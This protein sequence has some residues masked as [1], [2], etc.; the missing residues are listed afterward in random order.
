MAKVAHVRESQ[1]GAMA[2]QMLNMEEVR[3]AAQ[4]GV[5]ALQYLLEGCSF[6]FAEFPRLSSPQALHF[7]PS[8]NTSRGEEFEVLEELYL[9]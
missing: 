6:S 4:R 5:E 9:T 8:R 7:T 2:A 3:S 1:S